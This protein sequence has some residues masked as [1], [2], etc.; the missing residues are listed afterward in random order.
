MPFPDFRKCLPKPKKLVPKVGKPIHKMR[1]RTPTSRGHF[2]IP[3]RCIQM[4]CNPFPMSRRPFPEPENHR[5][6]PRC[7][8]LISGNVP[9]M[10]NFDTP[11]SFFVRMTESSLVE[12][13]RSKA[14]IQIRRSRGHETLWMNYELR[15]SISEFVVRDVG[16]QN[17]QP[18]EHIV[19][20]ARPA[21]GL[22]DVG[23]GRTVG[24]RRRLTGNGL[25]R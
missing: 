5:P 16:Q 9:L 1:K 12:G 15:F 24:G 2:Q 21:L 20:S 11:V 7:C 13:R 6:M 23:C 25:G 19:P 4:S 17:I 18:A 14:K 8:R 10:E 3:G 22:S